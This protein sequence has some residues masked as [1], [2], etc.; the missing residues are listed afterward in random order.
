MDDCQDAQMNDEEI[1][2][3]FEDV[4]DQALL[5]HG[6][7]EHMRDYD[8]YVYTTA[9]PSTGIRPE[10]LRYRF[11]CC[12]VANVATTV[13]DDVWPR[14]LD[15]RL[16]DYESATRDEVDGYVWGVNWQLLYPGMALTPESPL[17]AE[18]SARLGFEFRE[19]VIEGNGHRIQLIFRDLFVSTITA[20]AH[21]FEVPGED[22]PAGTFPLG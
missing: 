3:A 11:S 7:A 10:H 6:F 9:D 19:A 17:A 12:V 8:L 18:W 22:N 21:P 14:S 2:R 1:A 16:V 4:F 20:G 13:R 15:E 5:F